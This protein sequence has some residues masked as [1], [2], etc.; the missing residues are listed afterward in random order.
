MTEKADNLK[1]HLDMLEG[2]IPEF[3][4]MWESLTLKQGFTEADIMEAQVNWTDVWIVS[5]VAVPTDIHFTRAWF[6]S[7]E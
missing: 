1:K 4:V 6:A 3:R 5:C 2:P 7:L